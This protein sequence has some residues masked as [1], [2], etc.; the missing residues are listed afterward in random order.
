[1]IRVVYSAEPNFPA[2]DQHPDAVRYRVA[3][4]FVDAIGGK[5]TV[6]EVQAFVSPPPAVPSSI[7]D[8]QFAQQLAVVGLITQTEALAWV[9]T[10]TIPASFDAFIGALP[11]DAQFGARML[12]KGATIFE[13]SHPLTAAFGA[14][15]GMSADQIDDLWRA[16][17]AL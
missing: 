17:A 4:Y 1:M 3:G 5:P 6:N 8:R 2:T 11:A 9:S 16:A 7:S 14:A 15:Q 12:L 13:R 10:G